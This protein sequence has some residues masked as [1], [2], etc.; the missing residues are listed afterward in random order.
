MVVKDFDGV[1]V[2]D[3][4]DLALILRDSGGWNRCQESEEHNE[5]P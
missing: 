1:A 3:S 5:G 4:N 2:E